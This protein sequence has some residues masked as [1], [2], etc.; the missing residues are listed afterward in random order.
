MKGRHCWPRPISRR[1]AE[2]R[3][4]MEET[5]DRPVEAGGYPMTVEETI[6]VVAEAERLP[7]PLPFEAPGRR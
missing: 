1:N 4:A 2:N 3:M 6:V 5:A 7:E